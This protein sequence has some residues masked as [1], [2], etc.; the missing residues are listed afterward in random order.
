MS[1]T[2]RCYQHYTMRFTIHCLNTE[3]VYKSRTAL[4]SCYSVRTKTVGCRRL[5]GKLNL[6]GYRGHSINIAPLSAEHKPNQTGAMHTRTHIGGKR[7]TVK[8]ADGAPG[9]SFP[10][11]TR[12]NVLLSEENVS[13]QSTAVIKLPI[14]IPAAWETSQKP[15]QCV[16]NATAMIDAVKPAFHSVLKENHFEIFTFYQGNG[17]VN[18]GAYDLV[19]WVLIIIQAPWENKLQIRSHACLECFF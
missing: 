12:E 11:Q 1:G 8:T 19:Y 17:T 3:C 14:W 6:L 16:L 9:H 4:G 13:L 7:Q 2:E 5:L 10:G 15:A 18:I